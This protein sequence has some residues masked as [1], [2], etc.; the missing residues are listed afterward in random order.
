METQPTNNVYWKMELLY[1]V[2]S[3]HFAIIIIIV[4]RQ[5]S[6]WQFG[7]QRLDSLTQSYYVKPFVWFWAVEIP[8][9]IQL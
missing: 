7:V 3:K 1:S 9:I 8:F 5:A 6:G 4:V 2:C